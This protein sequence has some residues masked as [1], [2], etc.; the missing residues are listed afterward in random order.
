MSNRYSSHNIQTHFLCKFILLPEMI[1]IT[2]TYI[3]LT[4]MI[5]MA[6]YNLIANYTQYNLNKNSNMHNTKQAFLSSETTDHN[7]LVHLFHHKLCKL[8]SQYI[9][10]NHHF[11][12]VQLIL[13]NSS[14]MMDVLVK[15]SNLID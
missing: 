2:S 13:V 14:N 1:F 12:S 10:K 4:Y 7:L 6:I 3:L 15:G 9:A 5:C 11:L 8:Y